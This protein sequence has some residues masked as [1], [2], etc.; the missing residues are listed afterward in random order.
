VQLSGLPRV[1][2]GVH[3]PGDVIAGSTVGSI[4]GPPASFTLRRGRRSRG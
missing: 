2:T 1:L 3:H 4:V